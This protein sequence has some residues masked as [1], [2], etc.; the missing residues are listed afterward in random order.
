[1]L[2]FSKYRDAYDR[3][4]KDISGLNN[5]QLLNLSGTQILGTGLE[6]LEKLQQLKWISFAGTHIGDEELAALARL[7]SLEY[8]NF[9][10]VPVGNEGISNV[11]SDGGESDCISIGVGWLG[12]GND[13]CSGEGLRCES[14]NFGDCDSR[15]W[16][17]FGCKDCVRCC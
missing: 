10:N 5:L 16:W 7:D 15:Y 12:T 9:N 8:I 3:V 4:L 13:R 1:M 11:T 2:S 14:T 17:I 6:Y